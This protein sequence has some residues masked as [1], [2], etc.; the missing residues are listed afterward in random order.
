MLVSHEGGRSEV[1]DH[2][3]TTMKS[4]S[5][6]DMVALAVQHQ[7]LLSG[8]LAFLMVI[9]HAR[10]TE[11]C[12]SIEQFIERHK[13]VL[14]ALNLLGLLTTD[15][16]SMSVVHVC[17]LVLLNA[18]FVYELIYKVRLPSSYAHHVLAI[19]GLCLQVHIGIG[20]ALMSYLLTDE[21]IDYISSPVA[22][23]VTFFIFRIVFYNVVC[24]IAVRQG[25]RAAATNVAAKWW[26]RA[27][28]IWWIFSIG[29]HI[30]WLW[31]SRK[32]VRA[33][34]CP[35]GLGG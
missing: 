23:W 32:D 2:S 17:E 33:A 5:I 29:Y 18:I 25:M 21:V 20:G 12:L 11:S 19:L 16:L 4:A 34:L 27:V 26:L 24:A 6:A 7:L 31:R 1:N 28:V 14:F 30:R 13:F 15:L 3:D 8:G 35:R 10:W 22:Y 9:A